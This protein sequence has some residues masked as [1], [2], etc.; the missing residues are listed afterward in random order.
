MGEGNELQLLLET[1]F[2]C[3]TQEIHRPS[4]EK[5]GLMKTLFINLDDIKNSMCILNVKGRTGES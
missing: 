2:I 5:S 1:F 4:S 3:F